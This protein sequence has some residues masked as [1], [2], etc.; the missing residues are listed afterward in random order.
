MEPMPKA[1]FSCGIVSEI[2]EGR[3]QA[4]KFNVMVLYANPHIIA[5]YPRHVRAFKKVFAAINH[6]ATSEGTSASVVTFSQ[7]SALSSSL[8]ASAGQ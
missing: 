1:D 8:S 4:P 3:I 6:E 2:V 7:S 5:K